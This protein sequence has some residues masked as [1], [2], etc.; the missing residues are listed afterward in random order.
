[1]LA[2]SPET[3]IHTESKIIFS[4]VTTL[5]TDPGTI[6]LRGDTKRSG[7]WWGCLCVLL[8]HL[9]LAKLF[10]RCLLGGL[11]GSFKGY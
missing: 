9:G 1:M 4:P 3:T 7:G 5:R 6:G 11:G 2:L 8:R 10:T